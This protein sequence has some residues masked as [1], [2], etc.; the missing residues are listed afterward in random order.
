MSA[1]LNL[2]IFEPNKDRLWNKMITPFYRQCVEEWF[3]NRGQG[4]CYNYA[5]QFIYGP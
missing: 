3:G 2:S 5:I 1:L 4:E